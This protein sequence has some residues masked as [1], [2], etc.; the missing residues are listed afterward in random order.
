MEF[1]KRN[2]HTHTEEVKNQTA[3]MSKM[4]ACYKLYG[5]LG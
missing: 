4:K 5:V 2:T 1:E 3:N